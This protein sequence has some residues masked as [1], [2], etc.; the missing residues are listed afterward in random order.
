MLWK[1]DVGWL[2]LAVTCVAI[3]SFLLALAIDAVLGREA[4]LGAG[5]NAMV[6]TGGFFLAILAVNSY[7]YNLADLRLAVATGLLGSFLCLFVCVTA[8]SLLSRY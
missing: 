5:K 4:S 2:L 3:L 6:I 1:L 7:G 8:K